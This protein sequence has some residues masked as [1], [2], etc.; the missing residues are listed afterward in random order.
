MGDEQELFGDFIHEAR[1]CMRP[2]LSLRKLAERL[3]IAPA[4]LSKIENNL[5]RPPSAK[6]VEKMA[7]ILNLE[8]AELLQMANRVPSNWNDAFKENI[9]AQDFLRVAM[10]SGLSPEE[11]EKLIMESK[12]KKPKRK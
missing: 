4:Y 2:A 10:K 11:L 7:E 3:G 5:D 1:L 6:V 8:K 9:R 12:S